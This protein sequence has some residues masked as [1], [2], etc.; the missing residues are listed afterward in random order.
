MTAFNSEEEIL[1]DGRCHADYPELWS[2][3]ILQFGED[4]K[5]M[6]QDSTHVNSPAFNEPLSNEVLGF[7]PSNSE[8]YEKAPRHNGTSLYRRSVLSVAWPFDS[9][10]KLRFHSETQGAGPLEAGNKCS[11]VGINK[12]CN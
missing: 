12:F 7:S 5:E 11:A 1:K 3:H 8:I 9:F 10:V 2:F 4:G 6:H